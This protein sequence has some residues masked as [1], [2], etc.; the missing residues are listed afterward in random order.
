[1]TGSSVG[2]VVLL[3]TSD[4]LFSLRLQFLEVVVEAVEAVVP[5]GAVFGE[6][7]VDGHQR[8]G[9]ELARA[10]LCVAAAR[11]EAGVFEDLEMLGD[12]GKGDVERLG[13]L[14]HRTL[15]EREFGEDGAPGGI[16]EGLEGRTKL[17]HPY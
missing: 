6:P 2:T 3:V 1:M 9:L 8:L 4:I 15:A 13:K 11:D 7:G 10:P 14:R 12:A 16:G 17:V 5:Q